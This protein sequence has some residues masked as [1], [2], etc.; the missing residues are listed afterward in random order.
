MEA[1]NRRVPVS[2]ASED[3]VRVELG[4]INRVTPPREGIFKK[5]LVP[6]AETEAAAAPT[7]GD[8]NL[9]GGGKGSTEEGGRASGTT[10]RRGALDLGKVQRRRYCGSKPGNPCPRAIPPERAGTRPPRAIREGPRLPKNFSL[11]SQRLPKDFI[12][13][14]Q[15]RRSVSPEKWQGRAARSP[16]LDRLQSSRLPSLS[17]LVA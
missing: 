7:V 15:G 5:V 9:G 6:G 13:I 3:Q 11:S 12:L 8:A 14:L 2:F 10:R 17:P 1:E 16:V 4:K